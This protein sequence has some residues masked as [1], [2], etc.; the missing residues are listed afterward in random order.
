M[1]D[2]ERVLKLI[3]AVCTE[4]QGRKILTCAKAFELSEQHRI[5]LADIS[6]ICNADKIK[7]AGCQLGC[8]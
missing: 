2:R 4:R 7:I 1:E 5:S 3:L 8:F 6:K